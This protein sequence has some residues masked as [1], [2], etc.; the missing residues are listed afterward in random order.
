MSRKRIAAVL[1]VTALAAGCG[2]ERP[3]ASDPKTAPA[4]ERPTAV[5]D[6]PGEVTTRWPTTVIDD[7]DG[8]KLCIGGI[9]TSLPPQCGGTPLVRWDWSSLA[10]TFEQR[11]GTRW[12]DYVVTGTFDGTALTPTDVVPA[13]EAEPPVHSDTTDLTSRCPEPPGGWRVLDPDKTTQRT[14]QATMRA[15]ERLD[16]YS[17]SWVDQSINPA[18][19][20]PDSYDKELRMN[21]PKLLVVNVQVTSD[22]EAAERILRESWGGS[23][24]VSQATYTDRELAVAQEAL[25]DYPGTAS[26]GRGFGQVAVTVTYDDGSLQRW[27]DQEFGP[28]AVLVT[29]ALVDVT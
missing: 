20:S 10:G 23:L 14:L 1:A 9:A 29:S 22:V 19:D 25:S 7:G 24:C 15:A 28:G 12:G 6:A 3:A 2:N 18:Y 8:A 13:A 4:V 17:S 27:A 21:D 11:G 5:P 26:S 16:G